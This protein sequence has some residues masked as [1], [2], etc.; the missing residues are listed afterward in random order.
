MMKSKRDAAN[1]SLRST[2]LN[3]AK[4]Q[5]SHAT[6][7][8][9][10]ASQKS[11]QTE[12]VEEGAAHNAPRKMP[13]IH[14]AEEGQVCLEEAQLIKLGDELDI[15]IRK[16]QDLLKHTYVMSTYPAYCPLSKI[17]VK[18]S[19][20]PYLFSHLFYLMGNKQDK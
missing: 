20:R 19:R 11:A 10:D 14:T 1:A 5:D 2:G 8:C 15:D 3:S 18:I 13:K 7:E 4:S 9:T 17:S 16:I 12:D 6:S